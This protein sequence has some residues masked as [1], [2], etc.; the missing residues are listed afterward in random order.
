M[1]ACHCDI[2][3]EAFEFTVR[4][5]HIMD[6]DCEL[7]RI[8]SEDLDYLNDEW[9]QDIDDASLRRSSPVMRSLLI[10]GRLMRV[11]NMLNEQVMVDTPLI[12]MTEDRLNDP[13]ITFYQAGGA[14]YKGME[15]QFMSLLNR[16]MSSEE[17]KK[18]Y[19]S[20]KE[21]IGKNHPIELTKFMKQV[22]F[23][24][25]GTKINREEVIKYIANK[26]GGA[27]YDESRNVQKPGSK[28]DLE[29]KFIL[30]DS[31]H[32]DTVIADK[33]S[34]YYELLSIGQRIIT[35][36]DIQRVRKIIGRT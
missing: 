11:V 32:S 13:S 21:L 1:I 4:H 7:I 26:R 3:T 9:N 5:T 30:L 16:A 14:K 25:K 36:H 27:H 2:T 31:I 24:I 20:E 12:S 8:V 34:V 19:E 29:K 18:N 22:S 17:M 15:V 33:N 23:M 35:S 6:I 10:E 28:G